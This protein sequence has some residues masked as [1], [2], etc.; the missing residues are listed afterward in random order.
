MPVARVIG[1]LI[2]ISA[3][4][5]V[6]GWEV[7][8]QVDEPAGVARAA[9]PCR[10]GI[11]IPP[12]ALTDET[13]LR[14]LDAKGNSV[15]AQFRVINR[16]P[17][18]EGKPGDIEWVSVAFLADVPAKG[19]AQYKLTDGG[20]DSARRP[21]DKP[22]QV[23]EGKEALTVIN[24]PLKLVVPRTKF[25]GLGE[26]WLDRAGDGKF[27]CISKGGALVIEGADGKTYRSTSD[28]TAPLAVTLEEQGPLLVV[29]RIDGEMK[30]QSADGKEN[31]YPSWDGNQ[32]T[33]DGVK[34]ANKDFSLGFTVRLHVWKD[35]SWVRAFL[36]MR[37]LN[38]TAGTWTDSKIN[39]GNAF[40]TSVPQPGNGQVEA[41]NLDID[42]VSTANLKYRIG[43]GLEGSEVHAGDLPAGKG[44]AA[45]YQDSSA[46]WY[47][48]AGTGKVWDP[49]LAKNS[50]MIQDDLAKAKKPATPYWEFDPGS[51]HWT[52]TAAGFSFMGYRF[53]ANAAAGK[54]GPRSSFE[55][56]GKESAEGLRAPGWAEVDDGQTAIAVGCRWFW[57]MCPKA[58][59]L[60]TSGGT[61]TVSMGLWPRQF[62][63]GHLFEGK[64]HK[65]HEL[66]FD[67]RPSG[68][69]L[70]AGERFKAFSN[71]LIA[72]PG[73]RH[74]LASRAYGDFMLPNPQEWPTYEKSALTPVVVDTANPKN[75]GQVSSVEMERE[76]YECYDVWKFGD[77]VKSDWHHFGQYLELD[78][79]YCLMVQYARTGDRRLFDE[80]EIANR[81]VLDVPA[82]GGGYGHQMGEASHYYA[83]GPLLYADVAAE[84]FLRD[85]VRHAQAI[86]KPAPWHLRSFAI[87]MWSY[88]ALYRGFEADRDTNQQGMKTALD[89]WAKSYNS[90][91][92]VIGGFDRSWQVFMLGMGG[93]ALGRYCE[94]FPAEKALR[95]Q[96][97]AGYR[98]WM[99]HLKTL[100]ADQR[101][102]LQDKTTANGFAYAW[103]FSGDEAFLNFAAE[104]IVQDEWFPVTY[105]T[106]VCSAKNWSE[107]MSAQ[108]LVQVF[109]HDVDKKKHPDKYKDLP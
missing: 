102:K 72:W 78:V 88:W 86:T 52:T 41:V 35:Q 69:G 71:R 96:L 32:V 75:I 101:K 82:H 109:L 26:V 98:E 18:L 62:R 19:V 48:Q 83:Y 80:A 47:W 97:V 107:T 28:L 34:M 106:G 79:P 56:L 4:T 64:I 67:F 30:A 76:K 46:S 81:Q 38:G 85:S 105:R 13:R 9:D 36:T 17:G 45:L 66:V 27:A 37:N 24:G 60:N 22:V 7:P 99:E 90:Q 51:F 93:D 53:Y 8:L 20:A 14:V 42:L 3:A 50:E 84:P 49:R 2:L 61:A 73:A 40:A 39:F 108:R 29:V 70:D 58:I 87:T 103:R 23:V 55:D 74:N 77:S 68:K 33:P 16:R 104:N 94:D 91:T 25:A 10:T 44:Q 92:H 5:V 100:P 95:E 21:T 65:T 11:P 6:R 63:R 43:G 15:P 31:V 54:P 1:T 57:Q 59:E 89:W 12:G